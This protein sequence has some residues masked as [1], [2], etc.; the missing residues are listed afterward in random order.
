MKNKILVGLVVL[1]MVCVASA[2]AQNYNKWS[3]S[4]NSGDPKVFEAYKYVQISA[5]QP[6][7][8]NPNIMQKFD[9]KT[10]PITGPKGIRATLT[11]KVRP[12]VSAK[13]VNFVVFDTSNTG[14]TVTLLMFNDMNLRATTKRC[15]AVIQPYSVV[16]IQNG[17]LELYSGE[18]WYD[19]DFRAIAQF[20][21]LF[22]FISA[23]VYDYK[24][25]DRVSN[26][27]KNNKDPKDVATKAAKALWAR[28]T[29]QA[30]LEAAGG[31]AVIALQNYTLLTNWIYQSEVA[32]TVALAYGQKPK[33]EEFKR[34]LL[35]LLAEDSVLK[36]SIKDNTVS[37]SD[38]IFWEQIKAVGKTAAGKITKVET[39]LKGS[40]QKKVITVSLGLGGTG[41]S[42]VGAIVN[43]V[44]G[45]EKKMQENT[46]F[47]NKCIVFYGNK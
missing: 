5:F 2:F 17:Q 19:E 44:G 20:E 47:L 1:T 32:Y 7:G 25:E 42:V 28:S 40:L 9:N 33:Q 22:E 38:Q 27:K 8:G 34:H 39:D 18:V 46:K 6:G 37:I 10:Y 3:N 23:T 11:K 14:C 29:A 26:L 13:N 43:G 35:Y 15:L 24:I 12:E 30:F 41:K 31:A 4:S 21:D 16:G 45:A 36:K